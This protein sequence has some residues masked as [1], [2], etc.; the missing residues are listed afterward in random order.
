MNTLEQDTM[1]ALKR[2]AYR[3][4]DITENSESM[5][6]QRLAI[7]K[8]CRDLMKMQIKA[9]LAHPN[10]DAVWEHRRY[11]IAKSILAADVA[12]GRDE[13]YDNLIEYAVVM[14]DKLIN[15]LK[16]EKNGE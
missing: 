2:A 16:E 3:F 12:S 5:D 15:K 10:M 8:E 9:Q 7:E 11:E 14:A 6:Q 13:P 1:E 4:I